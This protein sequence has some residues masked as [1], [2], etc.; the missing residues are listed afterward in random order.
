MRK[1][2]TMKRVFSILFALALAL[3]ALMVGSSVVLAWDGA[4]TIRDETFYV[5]SSTLTLGG[6]TTVYMGIAGY[7]IADPFQINLEYQAGILDSDIAN[8]NT[9]FFPYN[10]AH[11]PD[12]TDGSWTKNFEDNTN[13]VL[14]VSLAGGL[15]V[16][17]YDGFTQTVVPAIQW[18]LTGWHQTILAGDIVDHG[19][20]TITLRVVPSGTYRPFVNDPPVN[21]V[22]IFSGQMECEVLGYRFTGNAGDIGNG[23]VLVPI[24]RGSAE[25]TTE[26]DTGEASF[27]ASP[28]AVEDLTAVATPAGAPTTFP[29]GMF[30]FKIT[31]IGIGEEVTLTIELPDPMPIGTKWWKYHNNTWS[32]MNIGDD[33]GDNIITVALKDGRTPDDEDST[34][35]QITDQGG[36]APGPVG[37]ETY[38]VNKVSLFLPWI[39]LLGAIVAGASVLLLRRRQA[40]S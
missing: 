17:E 10:A 28:G 32:P 12:H 26:T 13:Y 27:T 37:W 6:S 31:G 7:V 21:N 2:E 5:P 39:V 1:E 14:N 16:Y 34:P 38:P 25:V 24:L 15:T 22:E 35:G 36:P 8:I 20:G 29:H 19:D 9:Y 4:E 11:P 40:Q 30:T 23:S 33:D 3:S 18:T